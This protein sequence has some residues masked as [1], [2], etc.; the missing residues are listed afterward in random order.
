MRAAGDDWILALDVAHAQET[1]IRR[2]RKLDAWI[3]WGRLLSG[4]AFLLL[5]AVV[6]WISGDRE[7]RAWMAI[8]GLGVPYSA[9]WLVTSSRLSREIQPF[10]FW[11]STICDTIFITAI[12]VFTPI[13]HDTL[14]PIWCFTVFYYVSRFGQRAGYAVCV[15]AAASVGVL[16]NWEPTANANVLHLVAEGTGLLCMF[17]ITMLV[18]RIVEEDRDLRRGLGSLVIRDGL[19]GLCNQRFFY[20]VL[21]REFSRSRRGGKEISLIMLDIDHFKTLNDSWGHLAGDEVL[22]IVAGLLVDSL[23]GYGGVFRY[24]G[25]EFAIIL[26]GAGPKAAGQVAERVHAAV[27]NHRFRH[28]QVTTSVGWSTYPTLAANN[29]ALMRQ[30]DQALYMAKQKGRDQVCCFQ[31]A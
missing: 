12:G 7:D 15:M 28:G 9:I 8:A 17:A 30:A 11:F 27:R 20:E 31:G 25:E 16:H 13:P 18:G 21:D 2:F 29:H 22:R 3:G 14:L 6:W 24:G 5:Y 23:Q 1:E 26:P 4:L 10:L 19:T